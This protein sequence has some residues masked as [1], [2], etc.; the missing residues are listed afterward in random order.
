MTENRSHTAYI[1]VGSNMGNRAENCRGSIETLTKSGEAS[2]I[3]LSSFYQTSPVDYEDQEWFVN[4]VA[5][6]ETVL[7]PMDLLNKLKKI[8]RDAGRAL[9]TVRFGPRVLDM[10]IILYDD[11][12]INKEELII[13][14]PRMHQRAFVLT[15]LCEIAPNFI[16]PVLK[17]DMICLLNNLNDKKQRVFFHKCD[18]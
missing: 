14:H 7:D 5:K 12:V 17:M 13:P 4:V 3:S 6:I 18:S 11:R 16:H 8:E 9:D 1:C 10:D 2:L 15:G